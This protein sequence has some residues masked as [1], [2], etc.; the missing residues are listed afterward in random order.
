MPPNPEFSRCPRIV[1]AGPIVD[2]VPCSVIVRIQLFF[3]IRDLVSHNDASGIYFAIHIQHSG[4]IPSPRS[5][6]EP[7]NC[8][9]TFVR[10]LS[11]V[12]KF[13]VQTLSSDKLYPGG[14]QLLNDIP[15]SDI[16]KGV[17]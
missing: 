4:L 3:F 13:E 14:V 17:D 12:I 9:L 5:R 6:G 15:L 8:T 7:I 2:T 11:N 16:P 1:G 10:S